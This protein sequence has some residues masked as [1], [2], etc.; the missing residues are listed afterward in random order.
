MT[1]SIFLPVL[2]TALSSPSSGLLR[3]LDL[4]ATLGAEVSVSI[5]EIEIPNLVTPALPLGLDPAGMIAA[6]E[7]ASRAR[8]DELDL[9]L[10]HEGKRLNLHLT[11]IRSSQR[12]EWI[13]DAMAVAARTHDFALFCSGEGLDDQSTAEALI[14]RSGRPVILIPKDAAPVHIETVAIAWD[15]SRA[16][17]R[18]FHD[19]L[20]ILRMAGEVVLLTAGS[21]KVIDPSAA[22][23]LLGALARNA[24]PSRRIEVYN[25]PD[26][27]IGESLQ[28]AALANRAG[29]LV[30]GG[31]G[32]NR[33]RE[34]ILGGATR[35]VLKHQS[36]PVLLSH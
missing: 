9:F 27:P 24:I 33:I 12:R 23:E 26:Q 6:A 2:T 14:F 21:D 5:A 29:L 1:F 31:Y 20:P 16:A 25:N 15:G 7:K 30:M 32:H 22:G 4:A 10:R 11:T 19:A 17:T 34:F 13:G 3:G 8:A 18:A 28:R 35:S 36:L